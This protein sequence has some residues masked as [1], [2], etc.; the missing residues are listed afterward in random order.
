MYQL[1]YKYNLSICAIKKEKKNEIE[2][3]SN[4]CKILKTTKNEVNKCTVQGKI[5]KKCH[6]IGITSNNNNRN[7]S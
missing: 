2:T 6:K 3:V 7:K 1:A 5:K 4:L